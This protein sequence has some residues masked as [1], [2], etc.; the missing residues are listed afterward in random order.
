MDG[1]KESRMETADKEEARGGRSETG[2]KEEG[3]KGRRKG[4]WK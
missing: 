2:R 3:T 1:R 4:G